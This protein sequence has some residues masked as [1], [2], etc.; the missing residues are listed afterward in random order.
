ML[1]ADWLPYPPPLYI[2]IWFGLRNIFLTSRQVFSIFLFQSLNSS[3]YLRDLK[4][5]HS[6]TFYLARPH[7][8]WSGQKLIVNDAYPSK[9]R[10]LYLPW[11]D[12]IKNSNSVL[13]ILIFFGY[14]VYVMFKNLR[15]FIWSDSTDYHHISSIC[16]RHKISSSLL[17]LTIISPYVFF[18]NLRE[19]C[20]NSP[21]R[22]QKY[23][24]P[25]NFQNFVMLRWK[26]PLTAFRTLNW[27]ISE[28]SSLIQMILARF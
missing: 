13:G 8:V 20:E 2:N 1:I 10:F 26:A 3:K 16:D 5:F 22:A 12:R 19:N 6:Y 14:T 25:L 15:C 11:N 24:V 21:L 4:Q 7:L 27:R 28:N 18:E 23:S 9:S 17:E